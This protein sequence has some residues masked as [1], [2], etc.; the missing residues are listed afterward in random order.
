MNFDLVTFCQA[1][2]WSSHRQ[3]DKVLPKVLPPQSTSATVRAILIRSLSPSV[4]RFFRVGGKN[5]GKKKRKNRPGKKSFGQV[6]F[7]LGGK[8]TLADRAI[9]RER[10]CRGH[11]LSTKKADL[12]FILSCNFLIV[13]HHVEPI[14]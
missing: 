7:H 2:F 1:E 10:R 4:R 13:Q 14:T 9:L 11:I 3:T 8:N 6:F 5:Y 12:Q